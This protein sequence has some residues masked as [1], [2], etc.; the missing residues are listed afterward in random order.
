MR[1][2]YPSGTGSI[3][4]SVTNTCKNLNEELCVNIALFYVSI[5]LHI[6]TVVIA[7][8]VALREAY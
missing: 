5:S 8:S 7:V 4:I 6:I 2:I 3:L 1:I